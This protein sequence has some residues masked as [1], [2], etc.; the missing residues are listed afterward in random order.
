MEQLIRSQCVQAVREERKLWDE[1]LQELQAA[2]EA[3]HAAAAARAH[4]L[5]DDVLGLL[6]LLQQ[7]R[8]RRCQQ[9][10]QL[11][12]SLQAVWHV[13]QQQYESLVALYRCARGAER[14][15]GCRDRKLQQRPPPDC[16][17]CG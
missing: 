13:M 4:D 12:V 14:G 15:V 10:A 2:Q 11:S 17:L 9:V 3:R 1:Q 5:E 8:G 6:A 16:V 7:E